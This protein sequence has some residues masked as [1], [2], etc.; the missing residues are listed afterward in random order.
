MATDDD[1]DARVRGGD[2]AALTA[3]WER[4]RERLG[5]LIRFRLDPRLPRRIDPDDVL[6]EAWLAARTRLA[7][8]TAFR[9]A[10]VWLRTV[11]LQTLVDQH[12]HHLGA[13]MR[14]AGREQ[15]EAPAAGRDDASSALIARLSAGGMTASAA[16]I[17]VERSELVKR[18]VSSLS[19]ADREVLALRHGELLG[20]DEVAEVLGIE[21]KAASIRYVR[22]LRRLKDAL[23]A[24]GGLT[25]EVGHGR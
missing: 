6:Q 19:E 1:L 23:A 21:V 22:A 11:V 25:T 18:G 3:L 24:G 20:N 7:H 10:F 15:R 5:R 4:H 16:A 8:A 2:E 14:D 17:G 9:S 12:R 13:Q